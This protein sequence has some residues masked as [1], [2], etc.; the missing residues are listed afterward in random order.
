MISRSNPSRSKHS[1]SKPLLSNKKRRFFWKNKATMFFT[2]VHYKFTIYDSKTGI[3]YILCY[4]QSLFTRKVKH[5]DLYS[6]EMV[7]LVRLQWNNTPLNKK[8]FKWTE[9][10]I[11]DLD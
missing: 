11:T 4:K 7:I 6:S 5:L 2:N 8:A 3:H 9:N 1:Q 10:K